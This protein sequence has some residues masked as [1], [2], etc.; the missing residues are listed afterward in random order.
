MPRLFALARNWRQR[1]PLRDMVQSYLGIEIKDLPL[2]GAPMLF[3]EGAENTEK[4]L[5]EF[6]TMFGAAGGRMA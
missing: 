1:P 5:E 3:P 2:S 4:D 6:I